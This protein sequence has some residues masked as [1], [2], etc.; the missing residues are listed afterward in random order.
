MMVT[1]S[2]LMDAL[3][4]VVDPN[5]GRDFVGAKA[6]KHVS[7]TGADVAFDLELGYPA[8]SQISGFR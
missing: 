7:I 6:I 2:A 8:K 1:E 5:T 4:A 3:R